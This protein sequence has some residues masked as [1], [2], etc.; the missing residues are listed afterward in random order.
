MPP[1]KRNKNVELPARTLWGN[2]KPVSHDQQL[3]PQPD[4][5]T[6]MAHQRQELID[7]LLEGRLTG[8]IKILPDRTMKI[9]AQDD[10]GATVT[11]T[12]YVNDRTGYREG[13]FTA[14]PQ[15]LTPTERREEVQRLAKAGLT[16][17]AIAERLGVSQK[18]VSNDINKG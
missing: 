6:A 16:Q 17:Q 11:L 8:E 5:G 2:T 15:K 3:A 1:R 13:G 12:S 14:L 9:R 7:S 18:T 4:A 10:Q